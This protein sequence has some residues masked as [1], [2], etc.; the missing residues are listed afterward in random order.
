MLQPSWQP[1]T[2]VT[3]QVTAKPEGLWTKVY[4][5]V[6]GPIKLKLEASGQWTYASGNAC[7]PDGKR[8]EGLLPD[9]LVSSAPVGALIGKIGGS[10]AE[11]PDTNTTQSVVFVVGSYCVITVEN[12]VKGALFLTMNDRVNRFDE[13]DGG[14]TIMISVSR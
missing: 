1:L 8:A 11:K 3:Q 13:H 14:I 4:D 5:Y 6:E 10:S 7:G 12:A 9:G 2:L